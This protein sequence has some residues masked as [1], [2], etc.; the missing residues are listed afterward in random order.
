[1][2]LKPLILLGLAFIAVSSARLVCDVT[3]WAELGHLKMAVDALHL[4]T[5]MDIFYVKLFDLPLDFS[6]D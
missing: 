2:V 6:A 3:Q 1:M 5:L 4:F